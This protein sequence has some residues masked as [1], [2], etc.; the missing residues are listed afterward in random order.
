MGA[1][2]LGYEILLTR[3]A[4]AFFQYHFAFLVLSLAMFS[5]FASGVLF[6]RID[7]RS[8]RAVRFAVPVLFALLLLSPALFYATGPLL[9]LQIGLMLFGFAV[10]FCGSLVTVHYLRH[11]PDAGHAYAASLF[12]STL[13]AAIATASLALAS[14]T[15]AL[16]LLGASAATAAFLLFGRKSQLVG[17]LA[18]LALAVGA[19]TYLPRP[20][21][22]LWDRWNSFSYVQVM[23][24]LG[25]VLWGAHAHPQPPSL[26][27]LIDSSADTAILTE[28]GD[29]GA[30]ADDIA[31]DITHVGYRLAPEPLDVAIVGS[32]GG[33]DVV[34]ARYFH[35]RSIL[36]IEINPSVID[37]VRRFSPGTYSGVRLVVAEGRATLQASP[38][39]FSIIQFGLV[40]TWAAVS[41]G[42][43]ALSEN[44]LYTR[45]AFVEYL[46]KLKP[47]GILSVT[48]WGP[49]TNHLLAVSVAALQTLGRGSPADH[50]L[51]VEKDSG[52][53]DSLITVLIKNTPWSAGD[54]ARA[55]QEATDAGYQLLAYAPPSGGA[56][57]D[58]S[59][60]FFY[61][62]EGRQFVWICIGVL[63]GASLVVLLL[64]PPP[65]Q[66]WRIA[67]VVFFG[68]IG[69]AYML[70]ENAFLQKFLLL[71]RNPTLAVSAVFLSFLF[72]SGVGSLR[73]SRTRFGVLL[74][75]VPLLL[76]FALVSGQTIGALLTLPMEA[77]LAIT[78]LA[79]APVAFLMGMFFPA[80][81]ARIRDSRSGSAGMAWAINGLFSV[82]APPIALLLAVTWGFEVVLI[83]AAALYLIA[84]WACRKLVP[85]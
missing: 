23:N 55:R 20:S 81:F 70:V 45:E 54:R 42:T 12:G 50:I 4:S 49:E 39:D 37:A 46:R 29:D 10:L 21:D 5:L 78:A 61:N 24:R 59:P 80:G 64:A 71:I 34:G 74:A 31:H 25:P 76:V 79:I 57:T 26:D 83:V 11:A 19:T 7:G 40:D 22:V 84:W 17:M 72:F 44:Y 58:D 38:K 6:Q 15:P 1:C 14:P 13:G 36:A 66:H 41:S 56:A 16:F 2:V 82:T 85:A 27:L 67:P 8:D 18:L 51:T 30:A 33:R 69:A 60:F 35:P 52:S 48:R 77:K 75:V 68:G 53:P 43:F 47:D 32:G 28:A 3:A 62:A 9:L 73:A 65:S 63:L